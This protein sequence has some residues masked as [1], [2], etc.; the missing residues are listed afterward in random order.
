MSSKSGEGSIAVVSYNVLSPELSDPQ[1]FP[2]NTPDECAGENRLP[3][4]LEA[5]TRHV[6]RGAVIA[7]QEVS[8]SWLGALQTFFDA[9]DYHYSH[10]LYGGWYSGYMGVG[11]AFPRRLYALETFEISRIADTKDWPKDPDA[12]DRHSRTSRGTNSTSDS[13][14]PSTILSYSMAYLRNVLDPFFLVA[15]L[16]TNVG[17][18]SPSSTER[19][20]DKNKVQSRPEQ[21]F[22]E[23]KRRWNQ[24]I[25][26]RLKRRSDGATFCICTYHNPCAIHCKPIISLHACLVA[27]KAQAFAGKDPLVLLGDFNM[28]PDSGGYQLLTTGNLSEDHPEYP[29]LPPWD[30]WRPAIKSM[31]SAYADVHPDGQ[32]PE[33]TNKAVRLIGKWGA[34]P[35][36]FSGTLDYI[37]IASG[38]S[39]SLSVVETLPLPDKKVLD[40]R[41]SWPTKDIPSDHLEVGATLRFIQH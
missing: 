15:G 34:E 3:R 4:I 22:Y 2:E 1:T 32:E 25:L 41:P 17:I 6:D 7:L 24:A 28:T 8:I 35:N 13:L 38:E 40:A 11:M 20:K 19:K 18:A 27:E 29:V 12:E 14:A 33:T 36:A 16:F 23:S 31:T 10:T 30:P 39:A 5:L 26:L 37:F 9:H 21:T